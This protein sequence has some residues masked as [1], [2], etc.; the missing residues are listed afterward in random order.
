MTES[1]IFSLEF[2][3]SH[4]V[5]GRRYRALVEDGAVKV[6][7]LLRKKKWRTVKNHRTIATATYLATG[8]HAEGVENAHKSVEEI[9]AECA[10]LRLE[11][12]QFLCSR[13]CLWNLVM[14][15]SD[16][17]GICHSRW[18]RDHKEN[19]WGYRLTNE[20]TYKPKKTVDK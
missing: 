4:N 5:V 8:K 14:L 6:Q 11:C 10:P 2:V 1:T 12:P 13:A 15:F 7:Y 9:A 16:R 17:W 18:R 20:A 3:S 19:V